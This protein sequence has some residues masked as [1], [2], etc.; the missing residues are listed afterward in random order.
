MCLRLLFTRECEF[1]VFKVEM[2]N[3]GLTASLFGIIYNYLSCCAHNM[4]ISSLCYG[5]SFAPRQLK[6][7][8]VVQGQKCFGIDSNGVEQLIFYVFSSHWRVLHNL[9]A[10]KTKPLLHWTE[11][12]IHVFLIKSSFIVSI[13]WFCFSR[14]DVFPWNDFYF[15]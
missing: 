2:I 15:S 7:L 14:V 13:F 8:L 3:F 12:Y 11:H 10:E 9:R 6:G 5:N 1:V 4:S